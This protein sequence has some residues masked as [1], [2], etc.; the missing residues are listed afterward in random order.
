M[1]GKLYDWKEG[2][3]I[4][5]D[6]AVEEFK[7]DWSRLFKDEGKRHPVIHF[8]H[9]IQGQWVN[10][11]RAGGISDREKSQTV[12]RTLHVAMWLALIGGL[13]THPDQVIGGA[14]VALI[15]GIVVAKVGVPLYNWLRSKVN[16]DLF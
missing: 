11:A 15:F 6:K 12:G 8:F 13:V 3:Q 4:P 1:S 16:D 10:I 14:V 5:R 9:I 2:D 7:H